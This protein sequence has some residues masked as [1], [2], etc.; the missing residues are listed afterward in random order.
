VKYVKKET[1]QTEIH[2]QNEEADQNEEQGYQRHS[3]RGR[4][5]YNNKRGG[6]R[7]FDRYNRYK[8]QHYKQPYEEPNNEEYYENKQQYQP[9][10]KQY[11]NNQYGNKEINYNYKEEK[12]VQE[13]AKVQEQQNYP[14]TPVKKT[15]GKLNVLAE[16]FKRTSDQKLS[17][18]GSDAKKHPAPLNVKAKQFV[19]KGS[20]S[21]SLPQTQIIVPGASLPQYNIQSNP[22]MPN[23]FQNMFL[24]QAPQPTVLAVPPAFP[25]NYYMP[26]PQ[27]I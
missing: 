17:P 8:N 11:N 1:V 10:K 24:F 18:Q 25:P 14:K 26:M 20:T 19:P 6:Y 9:W 5:G 21:P 27:C 4:K 22:A 12:R 15:S 13:E 23:Y 3:R 7:R 16:P 2:Q